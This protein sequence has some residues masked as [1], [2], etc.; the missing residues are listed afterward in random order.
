MM[1]HDKLLLRLC[2]E[3]VLR[4]LQVEYRSLREDVELTVKWKILSPQLVRRRR[5]S[6]SSIAEL[7][8]LREIHE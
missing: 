6:T 5:G 8:V 4:V 2:E 1:C 7:R 3:N